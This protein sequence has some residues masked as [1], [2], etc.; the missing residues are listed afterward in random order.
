MLCL[1]AARENTV[2]A[3]VQ[4]ASLGSWLPILFSCVQG[5]ALEKICRKV[6]EVAYEFLGDPNHKLGHIFPC[7][8]R[9]D[10][11]CDNAIQVLHITV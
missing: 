10:K 4:N 8:F 11:H 6:S 5:K 1:K 7:G 9:I 2:A 3:A